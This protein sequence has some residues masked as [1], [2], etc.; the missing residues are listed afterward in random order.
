MRR[1]P[2]SLRLLLR[3]PR[4]GPPARYDVRRRLAVPV[5]AADGSPLLTNHYAPVTDER[6]HCWRIWPCGTSWSAK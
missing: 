3:R 6:Y 4:K 5:P 2:L 1:L